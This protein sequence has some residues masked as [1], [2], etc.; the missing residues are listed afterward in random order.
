MCLRTHTHTCTCRGS[1]ACCAHVPVGTRVD[2]WTHFI[3]YLNQNIKVKIKPY[4]LFKDTFNL[5]F[6]IIKI[7]SKHNLQ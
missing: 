7:N 4:T 2:I 3:N 1:C 6:N 5:K